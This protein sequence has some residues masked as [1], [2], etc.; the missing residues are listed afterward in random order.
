[1]S[2]Q[3]KAYLGTLYPV[4]DPETVEHLVAQPINDDGRSEW[5]WLRLANGDLMVGLFPRGDT[6]M[7][8][9]PE[10]AEDWD[11]AAKAGTTSHL[12]TEAE[13]VLSEE[14]R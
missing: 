3:P 1:M 6:Y 5:F 10:T 8:F 13:N 12:M 11:K 14:D 9:E 4:T 7:G 2:D